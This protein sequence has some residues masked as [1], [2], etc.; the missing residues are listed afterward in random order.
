MS[1]SC[2]PMD[3]SPPGSSVDG[4][5]QARMLEWVAIYFSIRRGQA[6][7]KEGP[8]KAQGRGTRL[9]MSKV[10][11]E[12]ECLQSIVWYCVFIVC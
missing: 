9:S 2:N 10:V 11:F 1:D 6:W 4:I 3:C 5:L 12:C 8:S 7:A